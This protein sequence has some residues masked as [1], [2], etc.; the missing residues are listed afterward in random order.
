MKFTK[1]IIS[2]VCVCVFFLFIEYNMIE[3]AGIQ[4]FR[5]F[6][7]TFIQVLG[8]KRNHFISIEFQYNHNQYYAILY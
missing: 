4:E 8:G 3:Q 6:L 7:Y 1:D 2:I 5:L